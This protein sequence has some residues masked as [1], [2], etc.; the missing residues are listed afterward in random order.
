MRIALY[1][2]LTRYT[3]CAPSGYAVSPSLQKRTP[4]SLYLTDLTAPMQCVIPFFV[5]IYDYWR[6]QRTRSIPKWSAPEGPSNPSVRRVVSGLSRLHFQ[7]CHRRLRY[8]ISATLLLLAAVLTNSFLEARRTTYICSITSN[9]FSLMRTA[10]IGTVILDLL[11]LVGAA[12][13][14]GDG[15]RAGKRK[16]ALVSWGYCFLVSLAK[17]DCRQWKSGLVLTSLFREWPFSGQSLRLL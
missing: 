4:T 12:E 3:E 5:A 6:N 10:K 7:L 2:Q 13:L 1:H 17:S 11:I 15:V 16:N 9:H 14:S 8:V